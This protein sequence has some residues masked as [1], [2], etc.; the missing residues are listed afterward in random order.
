M[1]NYQYL[2]GK[3]YGRLT[4]VEVLPD[5]L[6]NRLALCLCECGN[7]KKVQISNL[8]SGHV[9]S[10]GC[11]AHLRRPNIII[12]K[13]TY[14]EIIT[15]KKDIIIADTIDKMFLAQHTWIVGT[16]GYAVTN[17]NRKSIQMAR[18]LLDFP[19][20]LV[21]HINLNK[22]DNRRCNLRLVNKTENNINR[23]GLKGSTSKYK[24]VSRTSAGNWRASIKTRH[25]GVYPCDWIAAKAYDEEALKLYGEHAY[26]NFP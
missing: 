13:E 20:Q 19:E 23:A 11:L 16:R 8:N 14:I 9:T 22:L 3:K 21:D 4:V 24:G 5:K 26:L 17:I 18:L 12:E 7:T 15:S 10:C 25:I 2:I 1:K 6:K